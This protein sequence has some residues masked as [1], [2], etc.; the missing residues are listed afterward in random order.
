MTSVNFTR[1][2][3]SNTANPTFINNK[4]LDLAYKIYISQK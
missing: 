2:K 4:Y 3:H 1:I